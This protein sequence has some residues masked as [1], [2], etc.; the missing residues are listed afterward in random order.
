MFIRKLIS[1]WKKNKPVFSGL[2]TP[3]EIEIMVQCMTRSQLIYMISR[4]CTNETLKEALL[5]IAS[6]YTEE[7]VKTESLMQSYV[8]RINRMQTT[9]LQL[10]TN[11]FNLKNYENKIV[12]LEE[13]IMVLSNNMK[14]AAQIAEET[15]RENT[16]LK[17]KLKRKK[18][19]PAVLKTKTKTITKASRKE[20]K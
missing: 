3:H 9:I 15:R 6:E 18:A 17:G 2:G 4:S 1:K 19:P 8:N 10:E 13:N 7:S 11:C 5:N 12:K 14:K 16:I 20:L